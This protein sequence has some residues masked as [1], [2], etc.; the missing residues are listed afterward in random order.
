[1]QEDIIKSVLAGRDTVVIMPTGG[2]KSV[3]YQIPAL[4]SEGTCIVVSPLIALMKDQVEALR[5]NG[6]KAAFLN[7]S[8]SGREQAEVERDCVEGKL[9]L[10]YIAPEKLF[11]ESFQ[12]MLDR[13]KISLF[14]IDEAHCISFWGHDFRPEYAQLKILKQRYPG[15][16]VIALTATADKITRKDIVTQL[17]LSDPNTFIASF[18][19]P[20]IK[21][22][23]L[24][25]IN[26]TKQLVEFLNR[27]PFEA[28][29]VYCLSR[30]ITEKLAESLRKH[31][32]K[33]E[34]Y[35]AGLAPQQRSK[36][37]EAF[38]NDNIQIVVATIAFGMGI[39]KS[40]VRWVVHYNLPKNIES[41]YQEI[42]RSGRDG[43]PAEALLFYTYNDIAV[44]QELHKDLPAKQK[45]LQ[46]A[47]LERLKQ[48]A[49]TV[50]C[51]RKVL[52]SYFNE[53]FNRDCGNCDNCREPRKTTD[54]TVAAQ[55][56]LSAIA[57]SGESIGV[58]VL[59]DILRGA[60]TQQIV[61]KGFDQIK[62]FGKGM[63]LKPIEWREYLH[64]M[65]NT[66]VIDVAYDENHHLKLNDRSKR[67]LFDGE[68]VMLSEPQIF[69]KKSGP[70]VIKQSTSK[71]EMMEQELFERLRRLRK[72][73]A[74]A[75]GLPPYIVFNDVT[76][77]EMARRKPLNRK[78]MLEISGIG[79]NKYDSY[80]ER[81][82]KEIMDYVSQKNGEGN[83][84]QGSTQI[85]TFE[86]LK[87]GHS[88]EEVAVR[89]NLNKVTIYSHIA[90]LIESGHELDIHRFMTQNELDTISKAVRHL[91]ADAK[92]KDLFEYLDEA[93]EY[94]KIRIAIEWVKR[95]A[96]SN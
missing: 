4:V 11:T 71:R 68:T 36:V 9:K 59:V 78:D 62:T 96:N 45:E 81:F 56:A 65:I 51:R 80:G 79:F 86:I 33:A 14:A 27:H 91:G 44:Q 46:E 38:L 10:L 17:Q 74:D 60:R 58:N 66:G 13:I 70:E 90:S 83:H 84:I 42:G 35:H 50:F 61:S 49:E 95:I 67:V 15:V 48:Y 30:K 82:L 76:L 2:G 53:D 18:D 72:D 7:S 85:V 94:G 1:M 47:K 37:Q 55:K 63:D 6:V 5:L 22:N 52:L 64:Q 24:P 92:L 75:E 39:D 73:I 43:A 77:Q 87:Q 57:R 88:I 19:R 8:I 29:I 16:P 21:L 54:G 41:Y 25:G 69:Q 3:C 93:F 40:N 26:R 23:V 34:A 28:G 31:G 12:W 20:N 89:R 32:F